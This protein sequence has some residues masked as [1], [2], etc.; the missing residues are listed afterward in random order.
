[1]NTSIISDNNLSSLSHLSK[2]QVIKE[3]PTFHKADNDYKVITSNFNVSDTS[4]SFI[5]KEMEKVMEDIND[6]MN[7]NKSHE[8]ED[9]ITTNILTDIPNINLTTVLNVN[10]ENEQKILNLENTLKSQV[11][12]KDYLANIIKQNENIIMTFKHEIDE[13]KEH[14]ET[15]QKDKDL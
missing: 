5:V 11:A 7:D 3:T 15:I 2:S 14:I 4:T 6:N 1:M 9:I 12:E 13:L 10:E 8:N